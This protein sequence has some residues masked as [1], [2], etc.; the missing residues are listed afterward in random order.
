MYKTGMR[1]FKE[2]WFNV[3]PLCFMLVLSTGF[4]KV[5]RFPDG[6]QRSL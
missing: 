4:K 5:G 3:L 2:E 1:I 6:Q